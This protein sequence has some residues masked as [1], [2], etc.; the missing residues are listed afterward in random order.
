MP[1]DCRTQ[2]P[3]TA[4]LAHATAEADRLGLAGR[5]SFEVGDAERLPLDDASVDAIIC[6]WSSQGS[7]TAESTRAAR[8]ER[9]PTPLCWRYAEGESDGL[10]T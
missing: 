4:A 7:H 3:V 8:I 9:L 6:E 10:L 2:C 5:V 1:I